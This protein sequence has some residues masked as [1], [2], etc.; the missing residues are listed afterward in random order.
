M[1]DERIKNLNYVID[2]ITTKYKIT[3]LNEI[4]NIHHKKSEQ[5]KQKLN[6][7]T[8]KYLEN[9]SIKTNELFGFSTTIL[10]SIESSGY[11]LLYT[12]M[13]IKILDELLER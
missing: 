11:K 4:E 8:W 1:K 2:E 10:T 7:D 9:C 5:Y 6:G 13:C 3:D 12:C